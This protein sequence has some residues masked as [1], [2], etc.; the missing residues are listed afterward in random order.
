ME[1]LTTKKRGRD[2]DKIASAKKGAL[3][4]RRSK[5]TSSV[6]LKN[7][8]T[9]KKNSVA[10]SKT[11]KKRRNDDESDD[12]FIDDSDGEEE[13]EED[14][15]SL[16]DDDELSADENSFDSEEMDDASESDSDDQGTFFPKSKKRPSKPSS[17]FK[18]IALS[19]G[20]KT[21][22]PLEFKKSNIKDDVKLKRSNDK[23]SNN[24]QKK[25][26]PIV[27]NTSSVNSKNPTKPKEHIILSD[28][29]S[30]ESASALFR[31]NGSKESSVLAI[32]PSKD[33]IVDKPKDLQCTDDLEDTP[34]RAA[35]NSPPVKK[36][37]KKIRKRIIVDDDD[38]DDDVQIVSNPLNQ[39]KAPQTLKSTVASVSKNSFT[40]DD[41]CID[42]HEAIALSIAL[43]KSTAT[44]KGQKS[45][46]SN[47]SKNK[48]IYKED[49]EE[50]ELHNADKDDGDD[51]DDD[52]KVEFIDED[53]AVAMSVLETANGL[54]AQ[55]LQ[56]MIRWTR[57][58]STSSEMDDKNEDT[59]IPMGMIVDGAVA[60]SSLGDGD[61]NIVDSELCPT[62]ISNETMKTILPNA[63]LA[64]YQLIGVNWMS[65]LHN[66][67]CELKEGPAKGKKSLKQKS[68]KPPILTNVNGVLADDM[69]KREYTNEPSMV[70][71]FDTIF[72]FIC[73]FFIRLFDLFVAIFDNHNAYCF[74]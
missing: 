11:T 15:E 42:D 2:D 68:K 13:E 50:D 53:T 7:S 57:R 14:E 12:S 46:H 48:T 56:N 10:K 34:V 52:D 19:S 18:K 61:S 38:S 29:S 20:A 8:K 25:T 9:S 6:G 36:S 30:F 28:D 65:L 16:V 54:S 40:A 69:G 70:M 58:H 45:S 71:I 23:F 64:D 5:K 21:T 35:S 32:S 63:K 51:D 72:I 74:H 27:S 60:M 59:S 41:Y 67:K 24:L 3:E 33:A 66:M 37:F 26:I 31:D 49:S 43:E 55:V 17:V 1:W 44:G 73:V 39:S 62:W 47:S 4:L 22:K